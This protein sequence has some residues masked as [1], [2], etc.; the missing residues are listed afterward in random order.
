MD[1]SLKKMDFLLRRASF[2]GELTKVAGTLWLKPGD[3]IF[4][5]SVI[6]KG[7]V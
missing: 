7:S 5:V 1:K 3:I 4:I 6:A 2:T